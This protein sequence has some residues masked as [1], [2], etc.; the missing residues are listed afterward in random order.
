[1]SF[2]DLPHL[3]KG[4]GETNKSLPEFKLL[5]D[6]MHPKYYKASKGL[7]EAVNVAISLG[8]PLLITGEPGTGKTQLAS[9]I[10]YEYN[11]PLLTFQTKPP[12][13]PKTCF[14]IMMPFDDFKMDKPKEKL[15][16]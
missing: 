2:K 10:A 13:L 9:S 6:I 15:F 5:V 8:Q 7:Q 14:I 1:M 3:Y 16:I 12:L 11:L 4:H